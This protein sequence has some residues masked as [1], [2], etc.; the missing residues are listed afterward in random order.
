MADLSARVMGFIAP[1]GQTSPHLVHSGR[2]Y[3]RSYDIVGCM[4]VDKSVDGRST[5]LGQFDTHSW[6]AVQCWA[7]CCAD[8]EPGGVIG[9]SLSGATLS[10]MAA[11]PPSTFFSSCA[12]AAAVEATARPRRNERRPV[13]TDKLL[14]ADKPPADELTRRFA[15]LACLPVSLF[16]CPLVNLSA[17]PLVC[18]STCLLVC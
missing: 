15:L 5:P 13:S 4:N 14:T 18:L 6:Q 12:R 11:S 7:K 8:K 2:Q 1:V 16:T 3:P 9:V 10:S 17:R